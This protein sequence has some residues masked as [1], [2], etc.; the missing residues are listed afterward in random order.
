M[1]LS[2]RLSSLYAAVYDRPDDDAPRAILADAL[3]ADGADLR[4]EVPERGLQP[5]RHLALWIGSSPR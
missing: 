2:E 5:H 3:F 1:G 4:A